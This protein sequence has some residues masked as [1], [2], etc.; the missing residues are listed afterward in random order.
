MFLAKL[1]RALLISAATRLL[2]QFGRSVILTEELRR[3]VETANC[4]RDDYVL[5]AI[6]GPMAGYFTPFPESHTRLVPAL[7]HGPPRTKYSAPPP[8]SEYQKWFE[9]L[10][11]Q[12]DLPHCV[13]MRRRDAIG[14]GFTLSTT[15]AP[16]RSRSPLLP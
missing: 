15:P 13:P 6:T 4:P 2:E 5:V 3:L 1:F 14:R 8:W 10:Y 7:D 16:P 11:E 9:G 12:E